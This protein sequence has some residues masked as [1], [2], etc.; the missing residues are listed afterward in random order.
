MKSA[1]F[2]FL[3]ALFFIAAQSADIY[4]IDS[5]DVPSE[6]L[7]VVITA[8]ASFPINDQAFVQ[9]P[10]IFS[11]ERDHL[12]SVESGP[13]GMVFSSSVDAGEFASNAPSQG[14]AFT[15]LQYDGVD[16]SMNLNPSGAS[17]DPNNDFTSN[18]ADAF[19][20]RLNSDQSTTVEVYVYSGS[21]NNFCSAVFSVTGN[22]QTDDYVVDFEDFETTGSGCDITAVGAIEV[23]GN[24]PPN[25]DLIVELFATFGDVPVTPS[26]TRTPAPSPSRSPRPS[27]NPCNCFCPAFH[28][29]L[30]YDPSGVNTEYFDISKLDFDS[31]ND[32]TDTQ[33]NTSNT[34]NNSSSDAASLSVFCALFVTVLA[35]LI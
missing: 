16:G 27:N 12:L 9:D 8:G 34:S 24:L 3:F 2:A 25:V 5:F 10:S 7:V 26:R 32:S 6:T 19:H 15:L 14:S 17:N 30:E 13:S 21:A 33:S 35:V 23:V 28:C 1:V 22:S 29:V 4:V 31:N 20:I 18:N 11:G